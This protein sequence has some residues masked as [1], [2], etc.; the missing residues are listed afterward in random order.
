MFMFKSKCQ[1][2]RTDFIAPLT[3][4][5]EWLVSAEPTS[6]LI[7]LWS[8]LRKIYTAGNIYSR[9]QQNNCTLQGEKESRNI[10]RNRRRENDA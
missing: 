8:G 3:G 4:K 2:L 1:F 7:Y 6:A 10:V 5:P 9:A